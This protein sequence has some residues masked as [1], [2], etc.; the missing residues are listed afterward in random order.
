ML[1]FDSVAA[2]QSKRPEHAEKMSYLK[3]SKKKKHEHITSHF[4]MVRP[5]QLNC[6]QVPNQFTGKL[7]LS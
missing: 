2:S 1:G 6:T 5:L 3:L 7:P 4:L